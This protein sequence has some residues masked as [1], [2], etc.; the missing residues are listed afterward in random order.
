M[1]TEIEN[2][3]IRCKTLLVV[4]LEATCWGQGGPREDMETIEFG[5]VLVRMSDLQPIDER[6]WFIKP[7]LHPQ[8]SDYCTN[9]TSITQ[10]QVDGGVAFEEV[11]KL[12]DD[13]LDPH[14]ERLGWGSWGNYDRHQLQ[15]DARRLGMESPL[16][17]YHHTNLKVEFTQR[18]L[19]K[20]QPGMRQALA[21][22]GLAIEGAHHR[23][24]DDARNIARLLPWILDPALKGKVNRDP[25]ALMIVHAT[26]VL[27][28]KELAEKWIETPAIALNGKRPVDLLAT[29]EG[30]IQV[31]ELV[32]RMEYGI[33]T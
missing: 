5:A 9:L 22:C 19:G 18:Q 31:I 20:P 2:P 6:S 28:S 24:I 3:L 33:S 32:R 15:K 12:I 11:C 13:W 8:L 29:R 10:V 21:L 27:G 25:R 17:P 30:K 16:E 4:D 14:R 23:G 7:K 1:N 26:S